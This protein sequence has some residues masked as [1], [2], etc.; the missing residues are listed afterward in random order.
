MAKTTFAV[1]LARLLAER[2]MNVYRLAKDTGLTQS[3]L[4]KLV[5]GEQIPG[6]EAAA[7]IADALGV[8]LDELAGR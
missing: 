1:R 7:K 6:L 8:T 3:F 4:G 5:H 2:Q